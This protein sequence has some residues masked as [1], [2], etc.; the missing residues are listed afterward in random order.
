MSKRAT[1]NEHALVSV[2]LNFEPVP[3]QYPIHYNYR[4]ESVA[5][6]RIC[7]LLDA[8]RIRYPPRRSPILQSL[9]VPTHPLA[10]PACGLRN[11]VHP[12]NVLEIA[13]RGAH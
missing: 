8:I 5:I 2:K 1:S 12:L 6:A 9:I 4:Q 7:R 13:V 10:S 3:M 11:A